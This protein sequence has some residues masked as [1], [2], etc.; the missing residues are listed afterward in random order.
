METAQIRQCL[1]GSGLVDDVSVNRGDDGEPGCRA[2][3]GLS[4]SGHRLVGEQGLEQL[5]RLLRERLASECFAN[6]TMTVRCRSDLPWRYDEAKNNLPRVLSVLNDVP[7]RRLLLDISPCL[8]WFRGHFP[9]RPVLPGIVQVHWAVLVS[10]AYFGFCQV[11]AIINRLK[12]KNVIVPPSV[13]E[14]SVAKSAKG[15]I[16][17]GYTGAGKQYSEGRLVFG[18]EER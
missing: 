7:G 8:A 9:G 1:L 5:E 3:A 15:E 17:F 18:G 6:V 13:V 4:A 14:L 12:F 2:Y 16:S 10:A 11:P